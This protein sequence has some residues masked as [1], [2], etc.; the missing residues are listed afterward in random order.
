MPSQPEIMFPLH[1]NPSAAQQPRRPTSL[2]IQIAA[3]TNKLS[4]GN[5]AFR[6]QL[7]YIRIVR[8]GGAMAAVGQYVQLL[9]SASRSCI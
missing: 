2:S 1:P 7:L 5:P 3:T 4:F 9:N 8:E 6:I